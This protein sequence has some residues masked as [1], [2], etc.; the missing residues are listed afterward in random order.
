MDGRHFEKPVNYA[1]VEIIPP[2]G[3]QID[4]AKRPYVIVDPRAGHG[5]GISGFKDESQV[6]LA[7]RAG[8]PVYVIIFFPLLNPI[9]L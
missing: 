1:L 3:I 5:A 2:E 6:G 9:K 4:P 7:L 8:H